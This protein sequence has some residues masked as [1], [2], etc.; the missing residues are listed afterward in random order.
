M[1]PTKASGTAYQGAPVPK[2]Q[3]KAVKSGSCLVIS[4]A[5]SIF[6]SNHAGRKFFCETPGNLNIIIRLL[7]LLVWF[8]NYF[9]QGST[10]L[11]P[12]I[13]FFFCLRSWNNN[14]T[15]E[16]NPSIRSSS[17]NLHAASIFAQ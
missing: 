6:R 7:A 3:L 16:L 8:G 1:V 2:A 4:D 10:S 5:S 13:I 9:N 15:A 11:A 12:S 17:K 14:H